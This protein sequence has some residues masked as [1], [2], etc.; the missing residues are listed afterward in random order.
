M[1]DVIFNSTTSTLATHS[2]YFQTK[3]AAIRWARWLLKQKY[4]SMVQV[5]HQTGGMLVWEQQSRIA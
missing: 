1:Y 2:R 4:V 3:R 5:W